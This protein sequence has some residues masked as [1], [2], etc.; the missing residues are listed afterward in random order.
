MQNVLTGHPGEVEAEDWPDTLLCCCWVDLGGRGG[1]GGLGGAGEGLG[2]GMLNGGGE[3]GC[4]FCGGLGD[5][6]G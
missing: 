5:F 6:S 1:L 3:G 2:G 4:G